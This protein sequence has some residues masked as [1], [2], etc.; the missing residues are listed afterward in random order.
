VQYVLNDGIIE[1]SKEYNK[2]KYIMNANPADSSPLFPSWNGPGQAFYKVREAVLAPTTFF[3]SNDEG[4]LAV[5]Y[6]VRPKD[7]SK[8]ILQI[9][10]LFVESFRHT[11]HPSDGS[12]ESAEYQDIQNRVD[13]IELD[14]K[15]TRDAEK[16]RQE[17]LARQSLE[18]KKQLEEAAELAAAEG[19][20]DNL[21]EQVANLRHRVERVVKAPGG[22]LKS[23]PFHSAT[24][25]KAL[26][27]GSDVVI[28]IVTPYWYGIETEDGQH[29]WVN[30]SQLEP[31]P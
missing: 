7:T 9:D 24:T 16:H 31:V 8:T 27:P 18:R 21:E 5:R 22:D 13:A 28:L 12:V 1:G 25:L 29:G 11:V 14:K 6:V 26:A 4:T 20:S 15:Q 17:E 19:S 3:E 10:A 2:D 23:A 30:H